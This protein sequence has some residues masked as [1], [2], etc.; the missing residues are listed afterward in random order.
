[1]RESTVVQGWIDIGIKMGMEEG[2]AKGFRESFV[3][4]FAKGFDESFATSFAK[5]RLEALQRILCKLLN[6]RFGTVSPELLGRIKA[7]TDFPTL[8]QAV[9][10]ML[11][12]TRPE[13]LFPR[14]TPSSSLPKVIERLRDESRAL[15]FVMASEPMTGSLLRTLAAT[16]PGGSV[17]ELGTGTGIGTAWL[18]AGMDARASL[19]SIDND[20]TVS[21]VARRHLSSDP[22]VTFIVADAA[23]WLAAQPATSFDFVFADAWPGKYS[24]LDDVLRLLRPGGLYV[25]DDMLPLASWSEDHAS[26]ARHLVA[27]L[28]SRTDLVLTKLDWSTGIIVAVRR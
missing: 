8:K 13:D 15:G 18:L 6:E 24:H 16:K 7:T 27:E 19:V 1:M 23:V 5:G 10:R 2:L 4:G 9:S 11:D 21:E 17:L 3:A 20:P 22:R 25:I 26:K 12:I 28:E 14:H